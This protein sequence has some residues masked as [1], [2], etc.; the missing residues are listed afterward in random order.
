[1]TSNSWDG[2]ERRH[3]LDSD[4]GEVRERLIRLEVL[5]EKDINEGRE[6]R[7]KFCDKFEKLFGM[8][9]DLP[10]KER[11]EVTKWNT[12]VQGFMWAAIGITATLLFVHL[13]WK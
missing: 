7:L 11:A 2:K 9:S 10:C 1:M 12:V 3:T 8:F 4:I 13:G 6:W 5:Q